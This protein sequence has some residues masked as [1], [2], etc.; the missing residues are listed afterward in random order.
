MLTG[1]VLVA[2]F[3]I[4]VSIFATMLWGRKIKVRLTEVKK[5][6]EAKIVI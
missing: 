2:L 1:T 5:F 6:T 3:G 4:C